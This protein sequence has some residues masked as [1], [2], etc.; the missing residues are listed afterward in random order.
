ML[1][2]DRLEPDTSRLV[3]LTQPRNPADLE[4]LLAKRKPPAVS[5][6]IESWRV[7][8]GDRPTID[9][10][11]EARR[12][13]RLLDTPAYVEATSSLPPNALATVYVGGAELARAI[14]TRLKTGT[15]PVPGLGRIGWL[16]GALTAKQDGFAVDAR[17]DGDEIEATPFSAEL[18]SEVPANV[19]LYADFKGLDATLDELRRSPALS[20]LLGVLRSFE[21]AA[22]VF[23]P[24]DIAR[25]RGRDVLI[26]RDNV[27]FEVGLFM[28]ALGA[29]RVFF[30]IPR[31][32]EELLA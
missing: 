10:F 11:K 7:I 6:L 13:G 8:A 28:G 12:G 32:N 20:S 29:E 4:T 17:I 3:A 9:R 23:T 22:F 24:D 31:G 25:L 21:F 1:A 26:A 2:S 5:Q 15:G 30:I 14:G 27:V 16:A 18:P 19:L